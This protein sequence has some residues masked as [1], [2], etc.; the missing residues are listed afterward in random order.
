VKLNYNFTADKNQTTKKESKIKKNRKEK[1]IE[2]F[3]PIMPV[4]TVYYDFRNVTQ[5]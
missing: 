4:R 2:Y 5:A 3:G 1:V